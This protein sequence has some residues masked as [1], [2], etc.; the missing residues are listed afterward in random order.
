MP[1]L[2]IDFTAAQ[3]TRIQA[4]FMAAYAKDTF[5]MADYKQWVIARTKDLV[6]EEEKRVIAAAIPQ[7]TAFDPT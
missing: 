3:A 1:T 7:P 2:T 5:T 4:A 6:H